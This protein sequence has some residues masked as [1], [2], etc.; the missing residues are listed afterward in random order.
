MI[1]SY[2]KEQYAKLSAELLL[3]RFDNLEWLA[4]QYK[5]QYEELTNPGLLEKRINGLRD[6]I[7]TIHEEMVKIVELTE[8][9]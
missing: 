2:T 4:L 5:K 7:R 3:K 8:G 9:K 1:S 6:D